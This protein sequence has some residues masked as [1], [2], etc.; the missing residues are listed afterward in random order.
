M[1]QGTIEREGANHNMSTSFDVNVF[2][3]KTMSDYQGDVS[4]TF[5]SPQG[6]PCRSQHGVSLMSHMSPSDNKAVS[7]QASTLCPYCGINLVCSDLLCSDCIGLMRNSPEVHRRLL[8]I[9]RPTTN[10]ANFRND[11]LVGSISDSAVTPF[12]IRKVSINPS[13]S[14]RSSINSNRPICRICQFPSNKEELM[15]PCKCA[16]T[17]QHVHISCLVRWLEVSTTR[18]LLKAPKCEVCGYQYRTHS[19]FSVRQFF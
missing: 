9:S 18:K 12:L 16:G 10:C 3:R 1:D 15:S 13:M 7:V 4:V 2:L 8:L 19:C 5:G 11:E 17:M 6:V 14:S